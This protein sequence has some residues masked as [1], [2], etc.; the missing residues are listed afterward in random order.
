MRQTV[1]VGKHRGA[2]GFKWR[3]SGTEIQKQ[4]PLSLQLMT[5]ASK[6]AKV[7]S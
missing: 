5:T 1:F 3:S 7:L 2:Y 4:G 6:M